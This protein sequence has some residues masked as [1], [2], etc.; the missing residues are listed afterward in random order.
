M[1]RTLIKKIFPNDWTFKGYHGKAYLACYDTTS[2]RHYMETSWS[3]EPPNIGRFISS[4]YYLKIPLMAFQFRKLNCREKDMGVQ[5]S[6]ECLLAYGWLLSLKASIMAHPVCTK[7]PPLLASS[8]NPY[9]K[10]HSIESIWN[11]YSSLN[12]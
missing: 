3:N 8:P 6:Q 4:Y 12:S 5:K 10:Y 7:L 11:T 9:H 2:L 1:T